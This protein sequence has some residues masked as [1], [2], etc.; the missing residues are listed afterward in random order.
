MPN[1]I[2]LTNAER[3][4][5]VGAELLSLCLRVT[6]DGV[7]SLEE[8]KEIVKWLRGHRDAELPA[9]DYLLGIVARIVGDR[10]VSRD[11]QQELYRAIEKVLPTR[12]RKLAMQRRRKAGTDRKRQERL[13]I[14]LAEQ[15]ERLARD[16]V[17][18]TLVGTNGR[19]YQLSALVNRVEYGE[20][21]IGEMTI[22]LGRDV[23]ST[24]EKYVRLRER[25][26]VGYF[27]SES[28]R[29]WLFRMPQGGDHWLPK[30]STRV[31]SRNES[32]GE[33]VV[34]ISPS[35]GAEI[36]RQPHPWNLLYLST[37]QVA[38]ACHVSVDTVRKWIRDGLVQADEVGNCSAAFE[39]RIPESELQRITNTPHFRG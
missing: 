2:S 12:E 18:T 28:D 6:E 26:F 38:D 39:Y 30:C 21:S 29:A 32:S 20:E 15:H 5:K 19:T 7:I 35:L 36:D 17:I 11:E 23:S 9:K 8:I 22:R 1:R 31:L 34:A 10:K 4:S 16:E 25:R 3:K 13:A 14:A 33:V 37:H 24:V 27:V